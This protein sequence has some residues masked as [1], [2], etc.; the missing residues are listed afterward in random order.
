MSETFFFLLVLFLCVLLTAPPTYSLAVQLFLFLFLEDFL[1][2]FRPIDVS[3]Y[4]LNQVIAFGKDSHPSLNSVVLAWKT[5]ANVD[6]T[7][8][9]TFVIDLEFF[10][11]ALFACFTRNKQTIEIYNKADVCKFLS[12]FDHC[13][14]RLYFLFACKCAFR[15]EEVV[16]DHE[17]VAQLIFVE[18]IHDVRDQ[19]I[20]LW[21][22]VAWKMVLNI[23]EIFFGEGRLQFKHDPWSLIDLCHY[24]ARVVFGLFLHSEKA[25]HI[26]IGSYVKNIN[27]L[28]IFIETFQLF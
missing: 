17:D 1:R 9:Q 14:Y 16:V 26:S 8:V 7:S 3:P 10:F 23:Y 27:I 11:F 5:S 21:L 18:K 20:R 2:H 19:V 12:F 22:L 24:A 28:L 4:F 13:P 6:Q 15:F 25:C